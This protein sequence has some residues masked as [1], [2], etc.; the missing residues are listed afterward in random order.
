M[1]HFKFVSLSGMRMYSSQIIKKTKVAYAPTDSGTHIKQ[2]A[3][4]MTR[5]TQSVHVCTARS[6]TTCS[7]A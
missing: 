2:F 3:K 1:H 4:T 5:T 7:Q 6:V